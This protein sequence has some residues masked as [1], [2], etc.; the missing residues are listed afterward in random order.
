MEYTR[1]NTPPEALIS[2]KRKLEIPDEIYI[3]DDPIMDSRDSCNGHNDCKFNK[4]NGFHHKLKIFYQSLEF[5]NAPFTEKLAEYFNA[6]LK[7]K[8][9]SIHHCNE[10]RQED[11]YHEKVKQLLKLYIENLNEQLLPDIIVLGEYTPNPSESIHGVFFNANGK[12]YKLGGNVDIVPNSTDA[13]SGK[14]GMTV[15]YLADSENWDR[16]S[17]HQQTKIDNYDYW[18]PK[19]KSESYNKVIQGII[20]NYDIKDRK[21]AEA[22]YEEARKKMRKRWQNNGLKA[23]VEIMFRNRYICIAH[24][25]GCNQSARDTAHNSMRKLSHFHLMGDCNFGLTGK[26]QSHRVSKQLNNDPKIMMEINTEYRTISKAGDGRGFL[27]IQE[28]LNLPASTVKSPKGDFTQYRAHDGLYN[29]L[30]N[31]GKA[32]ILGSYWPI[33]PEKDDTYTLVSDHKG[34]LLELVTNSSRDLDASSVTSNQSI[35]LNGTRDDLLSPSGP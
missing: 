10:G 22:W 33:L 27:K 30:T 16:I 34:F 7:K 32:E 17:I 4:C 19:G 3:V 35:K 18:R 6:F 8:I 14:R 25:P 15:L 5:P 21:T 9:D 20:E 26:A 2:K 13:G 23:C 24:V 11:A 28:K 31:T 1:K 29:H 12:T